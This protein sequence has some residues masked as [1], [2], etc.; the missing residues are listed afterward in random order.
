MNN[1]VMNTITRQYTFMENGTY[2]F[3]TKT[4]DPLMENLLLT[5]ENGTYLLA[6]GNNLTVMPQKSVIEAWSK[7][8]NS[9]SW[10]NFVT[11]QNRPLE[12]ITYQF[13]RHY[14]SG[15]QQWNLVLQGD[16]E[17]KRDGPFS[18]NNTF[19]N[20]WYYH[21]PSTS[22]PAIVLPGK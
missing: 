3:F 18:S 5:K 6:K 20:A 12:K 4:F 13:T 9:D 16:K 10:G 14:F 22:Y 1:G 7:K 19:V 2:T 17:T 11:T 21:V 15:I 8:N